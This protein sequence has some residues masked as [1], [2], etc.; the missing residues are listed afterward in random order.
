MKDR[1]GALEAMQHVSLAREGAP[2]TDLVAEAAPARG[3]R[4]EHAS[5]LRRA[6]RKFRAPPARCAGHSRRVRP[7]SG[8]PTRARFRRAPARRGCARSA[9]AA[10][11]PRSPRSR[12]PLRR[13][14]VRHKPRPSEDSYSCSLM[15]RALAPLF[16]VFPHAPGARSALFCF[17]SC[18]GRSL[19]SL[20]YAP[21]GAARSRALRAAV[22]PGPVVPND[23]ARHGAIPAPGRR[24]GRRDRAARP[25]RVALRDNLALRRHEPTRRCIMTTF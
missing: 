17:P 20:G 5:R 14:P 18:A 10:P 2:D 16:F 3:R 11:R 22:R 1:A 24:P 6:P 13:K 12:A 7:R 23:G 4:H 21:F 9:R 15:R 8:G 25:W 19:R